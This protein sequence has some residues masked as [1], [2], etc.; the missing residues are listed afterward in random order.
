[1]NPGRLDSD[2]LT[3]RKPTTEVRGPGKN[4]KVVT[5][6][7]LGDEYGVSATLI[8]E[9]ARK[10]KYR[11]FWNAFVA[12][13]IGLGA[14]VSTLTFDGITASMTH[15]AFLSAGRRYPFIVGGII[16]F[17]GILIRLK[18]RETPSFEEPKQK[19]EVEKIPAIN[20]FRHHWKAMVV[21]V[22]AF[23]SINTIPRVE[24]PIR[25][26]ALR[27]GQKTSQILHQQGCSV[28]RFTAIWC[29]S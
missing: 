1:M 13:P 16:G 18:V 23:M 14:L 10:S 4:M 3:E 19:K 27:S 5:G 8:S 22:M 29:S 21:M 26:H 2:D 9:T 6:I 11:H 25:L 15:S 20:A 7:G 24:I 28:K 17:F 12:L